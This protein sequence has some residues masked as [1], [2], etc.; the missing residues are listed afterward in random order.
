M[1]HADG[2]AVLFTVVTENHTPSFHFV[3]WIKTFVKL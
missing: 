3:F 2:T 1:T